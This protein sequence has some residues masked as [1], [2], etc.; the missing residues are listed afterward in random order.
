MVPG[1]PSKA[2][3]LAAQAHDQGDM[4][5]TASG[6][7]CGG[8]HPRGP[9]PNSTAAKS[10]FPLGALS[11][12]RAPRNPLAHPGGRGGDIR[13]ACSK[14][15]PWPRGK[16]GRGRALQIRYKRN[17]GG[18][19]EAE[20]LGL[21]R[22]T[23]QAGGV[24][25]DLAAEN[26]L[27]TIR[28]DRQKISRL[29]MKPRGVRDRRGRLLGRVRTGR[30]QRYVSIAQSRLWAARPW[31]GG[32]AGGGLRLKA[33]KQGPL[34][35]DSGRQQHFPWRRAGPRAPQGDRNVMLSGHPRM[36]SGLVCGELGKAT[37]KKQR[38]GIGG[39]RGR[40]T[41]GESGWLFFPRPAGARGQKADGPTRQLRRR[42]VKHDGNGRTSS[43]A[44]FIPSGRPGMQ[45]KKSVTGCL[46]AWPPTAS[47]KPHC[48]R[49]TI[50][51]PDIRVEM[52]TGA[53]S[54]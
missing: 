5:S 49:G 34:F 43:S 4:E 28:E 40:A 9:G 39:R 7:L 26:L 22:V 45:R 18:D 6:Q 36:G 2:R 54:R 14:L 31:A 15:H 47:Q 35:G 16:T 11:G 42:P 32:R 20:V 3:F 53:T 23:L 52:P 33:F 21:P 1:F 29:V 13:G 38:W 17:H 12:N 24:T 10:R 8:G 27:S 37:P 51:T 19:P 41:G 30:I 25:G 48:S 46:A 44:L 50:L